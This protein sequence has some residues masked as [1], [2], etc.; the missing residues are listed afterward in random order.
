M[1]GAAL[2]RDFAFYLIDRL[3]KE[4]MECMCNQILLLLHP[5]Y[6]M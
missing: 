1:N 3:L 4:R 5:V 2:D 6:Q